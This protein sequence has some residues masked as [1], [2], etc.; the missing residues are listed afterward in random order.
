MPV[1]VLGFSGGTGD[2]TNICG[3]VS[4]IQPAR[5]DPMM[6]RRPLAL[7]PVLMLVAL[8]LFVLPLPRETMAGEEGP[9]CAGAGGGGTASANAS[10]DTGGPLAVIVELTAPP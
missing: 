6:S 5:S 8:S 4:N 3:A 2:F 7:L 1:L 10:Q 9:I